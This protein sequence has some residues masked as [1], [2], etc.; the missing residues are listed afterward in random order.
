MA[1]NMRREAETAHAEDGVHR[2][3]R[4]FAA[5]EGGDVEA[6]LT[7]LTEHGARAYLT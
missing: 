7:A 2:H 6:I 1:V 5:V 4:L 3:E